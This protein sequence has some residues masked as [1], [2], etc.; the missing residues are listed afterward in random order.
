MCIQNSVLILLGLLVA[1]SANL[2]LGS[3]AGHRLRS[4]SDSVSEKGPSNPSIESR[5]IEIGASSWWSSWKSTSGPVTVTSEPTKVTLPSVGGSYNFHQ[6]GH[7]VKHR[8]H[9]VYTD[10]QYTKPEPPSGSDPQRWVVAHNKVRAQYGVRPLAWDNKLA[11]AALVRAQT[12]IWAHTPNDVYGENIA[13]GQT[14]IEQV[15]TNWV[16]GPQERDEYSPSNPIDT[17]FTQVVWKHS[18]RLG[19]AQKTCIEVQG[20][21]LPQSPVDF[22]VCEYD[23]PGN[24]VGEYTLNVNAGLGGRPDV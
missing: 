6:G 14:S 4:S 23:P 18:V 1:L 21:G 17:H 11:N 16:Y 10:G 20:T 24:V 19:C 9:R 3:S 2:T 7:H 12:C 13:A 15:L 22:W 8:P 5:S